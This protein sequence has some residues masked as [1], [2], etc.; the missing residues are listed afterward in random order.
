M[1]NIL[2]IITYILQIITLHK[3]LH[4][5][6]LSACCSGWIIEGTIIKELVYSSFHEEN[7]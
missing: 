6:E 1:E 5:F 2:Q 3:I 7:T 4:I